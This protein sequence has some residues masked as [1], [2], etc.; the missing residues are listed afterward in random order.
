[1]MNINIKLNISLVIDNHS[2]TNTYAYI[3]RNWIHIYSVGLWKFRW[4]HSKWEVAP[5]IDCSKCKSSQRKFEERN[6]KFR[7]SLFGQTIMEQP[8]I[9][10]LQQLIF[11]AYFIL[12]PLWL[13]ICIQFLCLDMLPSIVNVEYNTKHK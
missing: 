1:M 4:K 9:K 13:Q 5:I 7:F 6:I 11:N 10:K 8:P 2:G 12:W 3:R